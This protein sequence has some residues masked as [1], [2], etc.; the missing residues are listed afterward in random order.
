MVL[1]S[2]DRNEMYYADISKSRSASQ[3]PAKDTPRTY[4]GRNTRWATKKTPERSSGTKTP[5][6]TQTKSQ[7]VNP[8][9]EKP[10]GPSYPRRPFD[11]SKGQG[12]FPDK[13]KTQEIACFRCGGN[14]YAYQ[15]TQ[16]TDRREFVR[17]ARTTVGFEDEEAERGSHVAESNEG[18]EGSHGD[19][20]S[21]DDRHDEDDQ[22]DNE[23][24]VIEVPDEDFYEGLNPYTDFVNSLHTGP[25][26]ELGQLTQE[27]ATFTTESVAKGKKESKEMLATQEV[28]R[29]SETLGTPARKRY[30]LHH[31][32]KARMRP[33]VPPEMKECLATW[34]TI[35]DLKAWT[36]WDS[37]STTTGITPTF[38]E[39]AK[40]KVDTLEDPHVLQLGTVGSRS[41]IKYGADVEIRVAKTIAPTYVDIANFDRYDMIIG[42]PWMYRNKVVL[43]FETSC[44]RVNGVSIPAIKVLKGDLDPRLRRY[45]TT[46]KSKPE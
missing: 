12:R 22:E 15:C 10:R 9:K 37:G 40:V 2:C 34:V 5:E 17:A 7:R 21:V 35:G 43:D 3:A 38:A 45:R 36:L 13:P 42:T 46:D 23:S 19:H 27:S 28:A 8:G 44:V 4:S 14:H 31:T 33:T 39:H 30:Q 1:N 20:R 32:G 11:K 26:S 6:D 41:I 18:D 25:L 16:K 24:N 29:Q